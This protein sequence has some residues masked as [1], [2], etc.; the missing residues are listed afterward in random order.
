MSVE[1][2]RAELRRFLETDERSALCLSG[3]WGVGKTH[4]WETLL[5]QAFSDGSVKPARYAYVSLFGLENLGDVRR[6]LFE[7]TVEAAAFKSPEPLEPTISSVSDRLSHLASKWR[8][9]TG[10]IRGLPIVADYS[11]LAEKAGFLDVRDQIVCF[12]DLERKSDTLTVR[13][14]LGLMSFLKEKKRCKVVLL[15]NSEALSGADDEDFQVQLEKVVDINLVFAPT[16]EEA[17]EIAAPVRMPRKLEWVAENAIT[18]GISNIRTI[19][20]LVRIADRLEEILSG[21]DERILKQ[22]IHSACL[23]GFALYQP[24]DAPPLEAITEHKPFA[25]LFTKQDEKTPEE[26]RWTELL[27]RYRFGRADAFDLQV[28]E[29]IR[30][31]H[32]DAAG[33]KRE[34][35]VL[36]AKY[37]IEDK[38]KLFT[39]AWDV[40]HDS[41][42]DNADEFVS[43]LTQSIRENA[44]AVTPSNLSASIATLKRLGYSEGV[45]ELIKHYVDSRDEDKE[46]WVGE[47][48]HPRF[49]IEDPDVGAAF[50]AKAAEFDD[51]RDLASVLGEIVRN[52]AWNEG[53]LEFID[54]HSEQE[55]Y[56][57][58]KS[59]KGEQLRLAIY[60]LTFFRKMAGADEKMQS[61]SAKAVAVL[62]RIGQ[63]SEIN[64][65][66]VEK[67]GITVPS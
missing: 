50:A 6:S 44:A 14:V 28:F 37:V 48:F 46:F 15:L 32:Y 58:L 19:F 49:Q 38:D 35:E 9:G 3:K 11:G 56:D 30:Q 65:C 60:G 21:F 42:D 10:I 62:Q 8:A 36:A 23:Y 55:L 22:A 25:H 41:F 57:F 17:A 29:S 51:D 26:I 7:N 40:Y 5:S 47:P 13:D 54:S 16:P 1:L 2:V 39:E 66:R 64:R 33:L 12:D 53:K 43:R 27:G 61:I 18:L 45:E 59:L 24:T 20:K 63:E 31:G 52:S 4:T 67:F 34:A